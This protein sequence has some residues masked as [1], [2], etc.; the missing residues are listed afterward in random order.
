VFVYPAP[1]FFP[2]LFGAITPYRQQLTQVM[3]EDD[4]GHLHAE[5][6]R[7]ELGLAE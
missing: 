6:I 3:G 2:V 5:I 4:Q 7:K 1:C